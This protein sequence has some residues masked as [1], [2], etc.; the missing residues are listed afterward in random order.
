MFG[1]VL[2]RHSVQ[3]RHELAQPRLEIVAEVLSVARDL[4]NGLEVVELVTRVITGALEHDSE[5]AVALVVSG[6][7]LQGIGELDFVAASRLR[8]FED[9]ED[10]RRQHV[11]ADDGE[12]RGSILGGGLLDEVGDFDDLVVSS[13]LNGGTAVEVDRLGRDLHE[14]DDAASGLLRDFDH[15][16]QDRAAFIDEVITEQDRERFVAHMLTSLEHGMAESL[17]VALADIVDIGEFGGMAHRGELLVIALLRERCL[18]PVDPVEMVLQRPLVPAGDHENVLQTGID[19]FLDDVLDRR[20]VDDGEHLFGGGFRGGEEPSSETGDGD[21]GLANGALRFITHEVILTNP[22]A[23]V[24]LKC[25]DSQTSKAQLRSRIRAA[26]ADRSPAEA[27]PASSSSVTTASPQPTPAEADPTTAP[28]PD[29]ASA[30]GPVTPAGTVAAAAWDLIRETPVRS[31]L[32]YAALPGEP[33]LDPALDQFLAAGGTV[34]LPVVTKVGEPLVFGK[35]TDSMASLRP[36]G[37]WG[38]REPARDGELLTAAQ[39][40]SPTIGLGIVFVPALGF[41]TD[42]ARLGNGG[43][44]Y[45]RTFGPQGAEPLDSGVLGSGL[46]ASESPGSGRNG[47]APNGSAAPGSGPRIVGVCFA[48]ELELPGLVAADWD[49]RIPEAVTDDGTHIFTA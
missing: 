47:S 27:V 22:P 32:A 40:L 1:S 38:I 21:H 45:D 29:S 11:A 15:L 43:G 23:P 6:E 49:L 4:H 18:K 35:V 13:G 17:G 48:D 37:R 36:Q 24:S 44:F 5:D 39:L 2:C 12:I 14:G 30:G 25:V 3:R 46:P 8:R 20:L 41:G 33:D 7:L 10:L 16:R 9:V 26:R 31:L 19:G 42:G 34:Y 28:L